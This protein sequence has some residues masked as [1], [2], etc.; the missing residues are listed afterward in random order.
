MSVFQDCL[1]NDFLSNVP[2]KTD[3]LRPMTIR[4]PASTHPSVIY[5]LRDCK[6]VA[7]TQTMVSTRK[8]PLPAT[9]SRNQGRNA[10]EYSKFKRRRDK[11]KKSLEELR[12]NAGIESTRVTRRHLELEAAALEATPENLKGDDIGGTPE[13]QSMIGRTRSKKRKP[14]CSDYGPFRHMM[15]RGEDFFFCSPCD[16]WD[17]DCTA[18]PSLVRVSQDRYR[19]TAEHKCFV[20]PT[21]KS[22]RKQDCR[23]KELV[24]RN[25]FQAREK[26]KK[27][28]R[29]CSTKA[30]NSY[31]SDSEESEEREGPNLLLP[32]SIEDDESVQVMETYENTVAS[33]Q[34]TDVPDLTQ[35]L[36]QT[37]GRLNVEIDRLKRRNL[38]LSQQQQNKD[39]VSNN[40]VVDNPGTDSPPPTS[41][42]GN[43]RRPGEESENSRFMRLLTTALEVLISTDKNSRKWG[44]ERL[45]K[46]MAK[47]FLEFDDELLHEHVVRYAKTWLRQN[48]FHS[49]HILREMDLAGGTLGYEGYEIIRRV[50]SKGKK[51]FQGMF[52]SSSEL[53]R[54]AKMVEKVGT[55][56]CPFPSTYPGFRPSKGIMTFIASFSNSDCASASGARALRTSKRTS[57]PR[58]DVTSWSSEEDSK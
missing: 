21:Q 19:C 45:G 18:D 34:R 38:Y 11:A 14:K 48:V 1:F 25:L 12:K 42:Q 17:A 28:Q 40:A 29:L 54:A 23:P 53:K 51:H 7:K 39:P 10:R 30:R 16:F 33:P 57:S 52:P 32:R 27:R 31:S 26:K 3:I 20:F 41:P 6:V 58:S 4:R 5:F 55:V 2:T 56:Y 47:V 24:V 35:E 37:V 46:Y 8:R 36:R 13:C 9:A 43:A 50:E 15:Y 49:L 22:V 44:R